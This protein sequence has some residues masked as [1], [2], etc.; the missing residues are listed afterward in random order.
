MVHS[1][2]CVRETGTGT[3]LCVAVADVDEC[4]T[5]NDGCPQNCLNIPGNFTCSCLEGYTDVYDDGRLCTGM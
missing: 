2:R 1:R 3:E 4:G 5:Q